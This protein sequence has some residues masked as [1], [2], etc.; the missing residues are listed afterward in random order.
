MS[1]IVQTIGFMN[2]YL[3]KE[4]QKLIF[5]CDRKQT[6]NMC[7]VKILFINLGYKCLVFNQP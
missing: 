3:F 4:L 5:G 7:D 6:I 1:F 2:K